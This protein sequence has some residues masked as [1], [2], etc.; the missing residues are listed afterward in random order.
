M[1]HLTIRGVSPA[2]ARA[3]EKE[4]RGR[5]KSLNQ[6][7]KDLLSQSLGLGPEG[8]RDN[9]LGRLAGGWTEEEASELDRATAVF[10]RVDEEL[11]K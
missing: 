6:T 5:G 11:W 8:E 2:L 3:L 7:V 9:G 1:K 4:A 10:E